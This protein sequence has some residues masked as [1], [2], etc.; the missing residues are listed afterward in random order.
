MVGNLISQWKNVKNYLPSLEG[1]LIFQTY[2]A[3]GNS[4]KGLSASLLIYTLRPFLLSPL[5]S[6]NFKK[7]FLKIKFL[8]NAALSG[9][10]L[11]IL[12]KS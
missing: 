3:R 1:H 12:F 7:K 4:E 10:P 8:C 9:R 5:D 6:K 11:P 2:I